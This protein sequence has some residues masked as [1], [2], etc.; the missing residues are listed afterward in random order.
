MSFNMD[1]LN[2]LQKNKALHMKHIHKTVMA[3]CAMLA[4]A[5]M[6]GCELN[7]ETLDNYAYTYKGDKPL[8]IG[9]VSPQD[10]IEVWVGHTVSP[11]NPTQAITPFTNAS[12]S[13]NLNGTTHTLS[14][15]DGVTFTAPGIPISTGS[16]ISLSVNADNLSPVT[17]A[18]DSIPQP[19]Q[20]DSVRFF[21][22]SSGTY[23]PPQL[24]FW[25][26]DPT[27]DIRYYSYVILSYTTRNIGPRDSI[28]VKINQGRTLAHAPLFSNASFRGQAHSV[29][30]EIMFDNEGD[31]K[32][33]SIHVRLY[34]LSENLYNYHQSVR[35]TMTETPEG[36]LF[37]PHPLHTNL[38]SAMGVM[39][40]Y[41]YSVFSF[42]PPKDRKNGVDQIWRRE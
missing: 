16:T 41:S 20:I 27:K 6:L 25:Y 23:F 36:D 4:M 3:T 12:V 37:K 5:I 19:V 40:A 8:I 34:S 31:I 39:G 13:V 1:I 14:S 2:S 42:S 10:G 30:T 11:I 9:L 35:T 33:D 32:P 7:I 22:K 26:N 38:Q 17:S 18:V 28:F 29:S 15:T 21:F 24:T